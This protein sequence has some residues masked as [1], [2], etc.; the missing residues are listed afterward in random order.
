ME[1]RTS[2]YL[3]SNVRQLLRLA[4]EPCRDAALNG[5]ALQCLR[6]EGQVLVF[7][8]QPLQFLLGS[9]N[10]TDFS[11]RTSQ[12]YKVVLRRLSPLF[13]YAHDLLIKDKFTKDLIKDPTLAWLTHPKLVF[14]AITLIQSRDDK[15]VSHEILLSLAPMLERSL[16]NILFTTNKKLKVPSLLRD[17][18]NTQEL[19][20]AIGSD[21]LIL[22]L[23]ILTGTPH[24]L[25][26]RNL[27]WH[28]FPRS[29]EI[30][31][32]LVSSLIILMFSIGEAL[33]IRGFERVDQ[34]PNVDLLGQRGMLAKVERIYSSIPLT[35]EEVG[36][37]EIMLLF[38]MHCF[39]S[40]AIFMG[41]R[42]EFFQRL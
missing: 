10:I 12:W 27:V 28:G 41:K 11:A 25:N 3:S 22:L 23:H 13:C 20:D 1:R 18:I 30:H 8:D 34:R 17:L 4:V 24:G 26:L 9:L 38:K 7:E 15:C 14:E 37:Q 2:S 36:E 6:K 31:P 5:Q 21:V 19:H 33:M 39:G 35:I 42:S 16:G 40:E 32:A 29:G